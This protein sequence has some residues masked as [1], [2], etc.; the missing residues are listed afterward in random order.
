MSVLSDRRGSGAC[1][2]PVDLA[3]KDKCHTNAMP[4]PPPLKTQELRLC[5][6]Q[7]MLAKVTTS[8]LYSQPVIQVVT[9]TP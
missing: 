2:A 4:S 8:P 5:L 6:W 7:R 3:F 1:H 9:P